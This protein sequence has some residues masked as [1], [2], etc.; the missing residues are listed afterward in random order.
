LIHAIYVIGIFVEAIV[1]TNDYM[2]LYVHGL[3]FLK[4]S[5]MPGVGYGK[6]NKLSS[7]DQIAH[8]NDVFDVVFF[9][10]RKKSLFPKLKE[11][12]IE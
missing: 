8:M 10:I 1:I 12:I 6:V 4:K 3:K 11:K 5:F 7:I 9:Q 2:K